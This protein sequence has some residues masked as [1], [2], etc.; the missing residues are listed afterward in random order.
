[1]IKSWCERLSYH[2]FTHQAT[3]PPGCVD[4]RMCLLCC[5]TTW[6]FVWCGH[7]S[8]SQAAGGRCQS[9]HPYL[10]QPFSAPPREITLCSK[11]WWETWSL[12]SVLGVDYSLIP[13]RHDWKTSNENQTPEPP[14]LAPVDISLNLQTARVILAAGFLYIL[15]LFC[16]SFQS[17]H[18][19][20]KH[21]QSRKINGWTGETERRGR[22]L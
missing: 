22:Q 10:Q 15:T 11:T 14:R 9:D 5:C 12:Q 6:C 7:H 8:K 2:R 18:I 20:Q 1:M 21:P 3:V 17:T 16:Q 13:V 4:A 19:Q